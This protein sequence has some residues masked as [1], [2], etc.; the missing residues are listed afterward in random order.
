MAIKRDKHDAAFSDAIR[1]AANWT[2]ERCGYHDPD[3]EAKGSSRSIECSHI[4]G[5]RH[6][7]TRWYPDNC[8][9]LCT[10]CHFILGSDPIEHAAF[11]RRHLGDERFE[12]L[13]AMAAMVWKWT[14]AEKAEMLQH[15]RAEIKRIRRQRATG[16]T[17]DPLVSYQ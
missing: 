15:Y 6:K 4:Y 16:E 14:K 12:R 7:S 2:C 11:A 10:S 9:S 1:E 17:V 13:V 8:T 5:R 3:G